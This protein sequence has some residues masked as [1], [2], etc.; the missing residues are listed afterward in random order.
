MDFSKIGLFQAMKMRMDHASERQD[1]LARDIANIDTPGYR[2]R[3]LKPLN[4]DKLASAFARKLAMRTTSATHQTPQ[5]PAAAEFR[6]EVVKKP[7]EIKPV[8]NAVNL[9]EHM[10]KMNENSFDYLTMTNLYGKTAA[11]FKTAIGNR[12]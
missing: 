1:L 8:K 4:F 7:Y 3:D 9:E 11:L 5:G 12:G 10:M 2:A 6:D